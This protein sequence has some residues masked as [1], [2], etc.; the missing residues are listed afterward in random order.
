MTFR[1]Q[2][3]ARPTLTCGPSMTEQ[4]HRDDVK[5]QSILKKYAQ[6]GVISHVKEYQGT[7]MNV[8]NGLDYQEAQN[9]I[10]EAASLFESVPAHI[11]QDFAN[12]PAQF[13]DF[14]QNSENKEAIEAYGLDASHLPVQEETQEPTP[15]PPK[16]SKAP[17]TQSEASEDA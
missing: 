5:I 1:K 13:I 9:I 12:D 10:A 17:K 6:T 4:H 3:T 16:P 2:P 15:T 7:Y 8:P 14:M 11:R